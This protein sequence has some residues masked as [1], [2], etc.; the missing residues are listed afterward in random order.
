MSCGLS[1]AF[2]SSETKRDKSNLSKVVFLDIRRTNLS[3]PVPPTL[4]TVLGRGTQE[5][6]FENVQKDHSDCCMKRT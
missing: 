1:L 4:L 3:V 6:V 5:M 2:V